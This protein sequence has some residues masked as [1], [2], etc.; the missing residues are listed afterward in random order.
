MGL[1]GGRG[2]FRCTPGGGRGR[3]IAGPRVGLRAASFE[4][5]EELLDALLPGDLLVLIRPPCADLGVSVLRN[6]AS[7]QTPAFQAR[8]AVAPRAAAW[9]HSLRPH[10]RPTA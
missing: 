1:L 7:G 3:P 8:R 6:D 9:Y 5:D 10:E 2:R 4:L